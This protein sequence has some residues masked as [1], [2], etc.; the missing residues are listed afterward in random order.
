MIHDRRQIVVANSKTSEEREVTSGTPQGS[1]LS[2]FFFCLYISP[3]KDLLET[4][5]KE[6]AKKQERMPEKQKKNTW[7]TLFPTTASCQEVQRRK[8]T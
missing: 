2:P 7:A 1:C 8:R 4:F 6:E 3:V 5:T